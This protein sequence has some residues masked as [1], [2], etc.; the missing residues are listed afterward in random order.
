MKNKPIFQCLQIDLMPLSTKLSYWFFLFMGTSITFKEIKERKLNKIMEW[1]TRFIFS[2]IFKITT[3]SKGWYYFLTKINH[4][5]D[6]E[7][8]KM[9]YH[10]TMTTEYYARKHI[11]ITILY[12]LTQSNKVK[13]VSNE[14]LTYSFY[15][16]SHKYIDLW[17]KMY[18]VV[19]GYKYKTLLW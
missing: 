15:I 14:S 17:S 19:I 5:L 3:T 9:K 1:T 4:N 7:T 16:K 12:P 6:S 18:N 2:Y 13:K 10:S 11:A 8:A